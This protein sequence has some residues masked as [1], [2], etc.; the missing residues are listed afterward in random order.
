MTARPVMNKAMPAVRTRSPNPETQDHVTD[1]D[2][3]AARQ[4]RPVRADQLSAMMPPRIGKI[5]EPRVPSVENARVGPEPVPS[6]VVVV[7]REHDAVWTFTGR[8]LTVRLDL[9]GHRGCAAVD[10]EESPRIRLITPDL[11]AAP[12]RLVGR[13]ENLE[14]KLG[15]TGPHAALHCKRERGIGPLI[16]DPRTR[17]CSRLALAPPESDDPEQRIA[18]ACRNRCR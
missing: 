7:R 11:D 17:S 13:V 8:S 4:H 2:E 16:R 1:R 3:D 6:A 12:D 9:S 15:V 14:S 18:L 5:G 10:R